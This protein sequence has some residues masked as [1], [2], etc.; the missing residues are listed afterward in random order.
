MKKRYSIVPLAAL[1][2]LM[3]ASVAMAGSA[4]GTG[5]KGT[6]HDLSQNATYGFDPDGLQRICIYCHAPHHTYKYDNTGTKGETLDYYPLWNHDPSAVDSYTMY[7]N[8]TPATN[9]P[10]DISHQLNATLGTEPGGV[11]KLCL[12]CHDGSIA[13]SAYGTY[14][15]NAS[16]GNAAG[17]TVAGTTFEIG[18]VAGVDSDLSNHH[19]IGFNYDNAQA[20]D[21]EIKP[22]SSPMGG[23]GYTIGDLLWGGQMECTTCHDVHNTQNEGLKFI[24][25]EDLQSNF[26]LQCHDK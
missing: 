11:S 15:N 7:E 20:S 9:K 4:P 14:G 1:G 10:N 16:N 19:P 3:C 18:A 5:I 8:A 17:Q 21:D 13:V 23:T 24:W 6:A 22:S 26:C 25:V 2:V 12:S